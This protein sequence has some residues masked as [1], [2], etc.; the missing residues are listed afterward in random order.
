[1]KSKH[2]KTP[3][4]LPLKSDLIVLKK[5]LVQ[6][7]KQICET[8]LTISHSE[9]VHLMKLLVCRIITF[10]ARRGSKHIYTIFYFICVFVFCLWYPVLLYVISFNPLYIPLCIFWFLD[11]LSCILCF[12]G[13][14]TNLTVDDWMRSDQWKRQE[15]IENIQD[16]CEKI[17]AKRMKVIYVQGKII[18]KVP[19]LFTVDMQDGIMRL[20][21]FREQI[22]VSKDNPYLFPCSTKGSV[23]SVKPWDIVHE[24]SFNCSG[25]KE[26]GRITSTK[27]R[28][29]YIYIY[30]YVYRCKAPNLYSHVGNTFLCLNE[31][32]GKFL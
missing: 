25:L 12:S 7:M 13:E 32:R 31:Y 19:I 28:L 21:K 1:M 9:W 4:L 10:N 20:N 14:P 16:E 8:E 11:Y 17:L 18:N 27:V 6:S 30:I 5:H 23:N 24:I 15:D 3:E 2:S 29:I 22:G 26:P